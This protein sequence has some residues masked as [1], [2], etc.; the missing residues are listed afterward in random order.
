MSW[1]EELPTPAVP[2]EA[3]AGLRD[4]VIARL[5]AS[6]SYPTWVLLAA[7]AGMFATTFPITILTVA[8]KPI[9][10]EFGVSETTIA[11]VITAP[12]L[13]SAVTLPLLGKLGDLQ[14]HRRIFLIGFAAA[15]V[16]AVATAFA[17]DAASLIG[18]R[19][20]AAVVGGATGPSSMAL[21]FSV[22][23]REE[24]IGA[25]GWWAM[26][27]AAAP[28]LG[29]VLGGPL[30]DWVGW[31]IVF[32]LQAVLSV[33]ALALA[34]F[35]LRETE[36][37]RVRFDFAGAF[38]LAVGVGG[39]MLAM[40]RARSVGAF[41]PELLGTI[42][43]GFAAIA[44]FVRIERRTAE[45]LLELT[46]FARRNFTG[47]MIASA[48]QGAAYMGAFVLAPLALYAIFSLSITQA[49][50]VMLL[51][52]LTLT[53]ASHLGAR[54]AMAVGERRAATVG[55][56]VLT[57]SLGVIAWAVGRGT[58]VGFGAGL[59]LQGLGYGLAGPSLSSAVA[60]AVPDSDLGI[61]SAG[62][63]LMGTLGTAFG[64]TALLLMYGGDDSGAVFQRAYLAA[65]GF[66]ALSLVGALWMQDEQETRC[67]DAIRSA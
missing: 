22:Y 30:V 35:V 6:G 5:E 66:A 28:A 32:V 53:I 58:L 1:P 44:W 39:W 54:L 57:T 49:S 17:W 33:G 13:C 42:V 48:F 16:T 25:M 23:E 41:S 51:R 63:R 14:G 46:F 12:M 4:R 11:W 59:V 2:S 40:A 38:A 31:R 24:R 20:V 52:T 29:L 36:R 3:R 47:P 56:G 67:P 50:A 27:G 10:V 8:L 64:I 62:S 55:S 19:T 18:L 60:N 34:A 26:T 37:Q 7:L 15:T 61:A 65:A 9:A 21:I 45:P 43:L